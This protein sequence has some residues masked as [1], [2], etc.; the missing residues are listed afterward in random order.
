MIAIIVN[1]GLLHRCAVQSYHSVDRVAR[2]LA[3]K[4][5]R[6]LSI[7]MSHLRI[8]VRHHACNP[9]QIQITH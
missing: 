5:G 3:A 4:Y 7:L 2:F 9:I 8:T 1:Y 6:L